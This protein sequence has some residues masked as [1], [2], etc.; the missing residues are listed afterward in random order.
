ML[1]WWPSFIH[2]QKTVAAESAITAH[3][4]SINNAY[5]KS[6]FPK[7]CML[8]LYSRRVT[9]NMIYICPCR[10][11][12]CPVPGNCQCSPCSLLPPVPGACGDDGCLLIYHWSQSVSQPFCGS[13]GRNGWDFSNLVVQGR[14]KQLMQPAG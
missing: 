3:W 6:A 10:P 1:L 7:L 2:L 13:Y 8:F 9:T 14:E 11:S 12:F 4:F 5:I